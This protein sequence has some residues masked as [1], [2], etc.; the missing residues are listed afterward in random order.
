MATKTITINGMT[1][2]HCVMRVKNAIEGLP[3][4]EELAVAIG[5]AS[6]SFD[7]SKIQEKDIENAIRNAGYSIPG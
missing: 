7:E 2:Q 4:V 5:T 1:C 6:V 3:G